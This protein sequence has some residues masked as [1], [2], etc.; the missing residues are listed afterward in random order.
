MTSKMLIEIWAGKLVTIVLLMFK[1]P[2]G[3]TVLCVNLLNS[4]DRFSSV[5]ISTALYTKI[6]STWLQNT[7]NISSP[8][9]ATF[10]TNTR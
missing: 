8:S 7:T 9:A 10:S 1:K 5:I 6:V 3:G 4:S 2:V